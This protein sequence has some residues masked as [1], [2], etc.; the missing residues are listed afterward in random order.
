MKEKL[1]HND[2]KQLFAVAN[3]LLLYYPT[4]PSLSFINGRLGIAALFY[5][6]SEFIGNDLYKSIADE[7][8]RE[9]FV[10]FKTKKIA[11]FNLFELGLGISILIDKGAISADFKS[12]LKEIDRLLSTFNAEIAQN[13]QDNSQLSWIGMYIL[14]STRLLGSSKTD[15]IGKALDIYEKFNGF[16]H[17]TT[18]E[19]N[20]LLYFLT[21]ILTIKKYNNKAFNL[22][23]KIDDDI[24]SSFQKSL[25]YDYKILV[26]AFETEEFNISHY[27]PNLINELKKNSSEYDNIDIFSKESLHSFIFGST[28]RTEELNLDISI[29]I[30]KRQSRIMDA[31]FQINNGLAGIGIAILNSKK[32]NESPVYKIAD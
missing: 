9:L 16:T 6:F 31:D 11:L 8:L 7:T 21:N 18:L 10:K 5:E 15:L 19:V 24:F 14:V 20:A 32:Y 25:D 29:A 13:I 27:L 30:E 4:V 2:N 28:V 26:K 3:T 1:N 17:L 12:F 23:K 22:L